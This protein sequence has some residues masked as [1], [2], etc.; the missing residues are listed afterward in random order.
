M[1]L[2]RYDAAC[3]AVAECN[4]LDEAKGIHDKAEA[5]TEPTSKGADTE[6]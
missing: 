5:M 3:R 1:T 6:K 2:V 4:S